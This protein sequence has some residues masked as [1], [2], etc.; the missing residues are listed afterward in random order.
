MTVRVLITDPVD[1]R[2]PE[3]LRAAGVQV[4][5]RPDIGPEELTAIIGQYDALV[6]RGRTKLR[7]PLLEAGAKGRLRAICRAGVGLDNIDLEAA[8]ELGVAVFN[9]PEASTEAVAELTVALILALARRLP[10]AD[11]SMKEGRWAKRE[12]MGW[13]LAGKTLGIL[14]FGRIGQRV[15]ELCSAFRMRILAFRRTRPPGIEAVL[16]RTGAK[17]VP[18]EELLRSSDILTIHV[19]LTPQTYHMIGEREL[20]MMKDGAFL[21]NTARG[22]VIDERA[23]L[24][25]L[26]EG[27]LAGA[28]LD[29]FEEEPLSGVSLELAKLPNVIAT[30]HIGGQTAEAQRAASELAARKLMEFFRSQGLL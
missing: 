3:L 15:A 5:L 19:P 25:A 30:P 1:P 6:V 27:R 12:L 13:E 17:L 21:V 16:A 10:Y 9:T 11:K 2:G 18:F 29:V 26:K 14:G 4:D 23:L 22:G 8:H 7:R 28:A 24:K 20:N